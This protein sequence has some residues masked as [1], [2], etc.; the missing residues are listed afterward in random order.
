[1]REYRDASGR[2]S[3]DIVGDEQTLRVYGSRLEV[4]C[5]GRRVRRLDGL[6][7]SYWDYE[8]EGATIVLHW[9]TFAGISLH[10]EDGS[11][12]DLLRRV[13]DRLSEPGASPQGGAAGRLG[14]SNITEGP[15]PVS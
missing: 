4:S 7:Q 8:V 12:D 15:P 11:R 3:I 2:L 1:M 5:G 13:A 6:D 10:V 14:N 9:D